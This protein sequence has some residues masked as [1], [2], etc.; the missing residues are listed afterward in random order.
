MRCRLWADPRRRHPC[1]AR[2]QHLSLVCDPVLRPAD[3]AAS[4]PMP[5]C[6]RWNARA[7]VVFAELRYCWSHPLTPDCIGLRSRYYDGE[8]ASVVEVHALPSGH[9]SKGS[10]VAE[11]FSE[12]VEAVRF[13]RAEA[14]LRLVIITTNS[15]GELSWRSFPLDVMRKVQHL[16]I[17]LSRFPRTFLSGTGNTQMASR[18]TL[19][20]RSKLN[21]RVRASHF[22][23]DVG[24]NVRGNTEMI[25]QFTQISCF[26]S[27]AVAAVCWASRAAFAAPAG[28]SRAIVGI[29]PGHGCAHPQRHHGR[30]RYIL[31]RCVGP[32][33]PDRYG[34]A[35]YWRVRVKYRGNLAIVAVD[36][37]PTPAGPEGTLALL[38]HRAPDNGVP[39][40]LVRRNDRCCEAVLQR[41]AVSVAISPA[42]T[43]SPF[44]S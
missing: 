35:S 2:R 15:N 16:G 42:H 39:Y 21:Y 29:E 23:A 12:R 13:V 17:F 38:M 32:R 27:F 10:T 5:S 31:R 20:A 24:G 33:P 11:A 44:D 7:S 26:Q 22:S 18:L 30:R 28:E 14:Q 8:E 43:H 34:L 25:Q 1:G 3:V 4:L 6:E 41:R 19:R 37:L 36:T 40:L 9:P